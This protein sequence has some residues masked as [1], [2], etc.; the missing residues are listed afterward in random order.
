MPPFPT[1]KVSR[2]AKRSEDSIN[3]GAIIGAVI[4][5]LAALAIIW[6]C[7]FNL[8]SHSSAHHDH[9][10]RHHRRH[11]SRRQH[12]AYDDAG[13]FDDAGAFDDGD[14]APIPMHPAP[15]HHKRKRDDDPDEG[16][17]HLTTGKR[18]R[19]E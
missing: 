11:R 10:R 1:Q 4:G 9:D 8:E 14:D 13:S 19:T 15:A 18:R 7:C 3:V 6:W 17:R 2:L 12:S 16:W 5:S